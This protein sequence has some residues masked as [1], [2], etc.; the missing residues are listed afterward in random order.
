[1]P[2]F[3]IFVTL[4]N[5]DNMNFT[6]SSSELLHGLLAGL[7]VITKTTSPILDNF[8]FELKGETLEVTA[9]D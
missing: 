2:N 4:I 1:M 5:E 6:V 7:K 3:T 8:L 9:S